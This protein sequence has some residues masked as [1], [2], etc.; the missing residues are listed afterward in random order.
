MTEKNVNYFSTGYKTNA[1]RNT[2]ISI[3]LELFLLIFTFLSRTLFIHF[4]NADYLGINGLFS[5]VLSVLSV[6]DLGINTVFLFL[7]YKPISIND[8][9]KV[10]CLIK[11]V[12]KWYL[13]I[14]FSIFALGI[15]LV[16]FLQFIINGSELLLKDLRL[17]YLLFL[18]NS[19]FPYFIEYK[20]S[21]LRADQRM[22]LLK[23][24]DTVFSILTH[25]SQII[26]LYFTKNYLFYLI[27][28][29]LF[30]IIKVFVI[31]LIVNKKYPFLKDKTTATFNSEEKQKFFSDIKSTFLYRI[32]GMIMNSTDNILISVI[33]GTV[34]VGYY[35]NYLLIISSITLFIS[36][37]NQAI[38]GTLGSYNSK[39]TAAEKLGL[40]RFLILCYFFISSFCTSCFISVFND[41]IFLWIGKYDSVYILPHF[42]VVVFSLNF[43]I[44]CILNPLWMFRETTGQ[45]KEVRFIMLVAAILN[46][47]FSIVL[48]YFFGLAGIIGSTS[49]S[50]LLTLFW[51]EP[52]ILYRKVFKESV[53][54]YWLLLAKLLL[55]SVISVC[56]C[57][58]INNLISIGWIQIFVK[59]FICLFINVI[60]FIFP[61]IRTREFSFGLKLLKRRK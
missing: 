56:C 2:I 50:K 44:N 34:I 13:I 12:R 7:L 17:Y 49:I 21:L 15:M 14:A 27:V 35:S 3:V 22:F 57:V 60:I 20:A 47:L 53:K 9:E 32:S 61:N 51:I 31:S 55:C 24:C 19:V 40:F 23:I 33:L 16:P 8:Q 43:F 26:I 42:A 29:N 52:K 54:S 6:A 36:A 41:F 4:L 5:N 11:L 39:K 58:V 30:T 37:F 46:I 45:F 48:G 25:I 1:L 38:I 18:T 59:I 10:S 28:M